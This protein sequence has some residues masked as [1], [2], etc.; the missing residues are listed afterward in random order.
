MTFRRK[1]CVSPPP[2]TAGRRSQTRMIPMLR[3]TGPLSPFSRA[4]GKPVQGIKCNSNILFLNLLIFIEVSCNIHIGY[5][6]SSLSSLTFSSSR[7]S[8]AVHHHRLV[9]VFSVWSSVLPVCGSRQTF[10]FTDRR[11]PSG[12]GLALTGPDWPW[13]STSRQSFSLAI[14][15][16]QKV[17]NIGQFLF[18]M[19]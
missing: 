12:V 2:L 4:T 15:V 17:R 10:L 18:F 3:V 19:L 11:L 5:R 6:V 8:S 1:L 9:S 7:C 16:V 14:I 13:L